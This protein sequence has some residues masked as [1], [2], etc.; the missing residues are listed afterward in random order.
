VKLGMSL[1]GRTALASGA[2]KWITGE[3]ARE[4]VQHWRARSSAVLTGIGTVLADD[5]RLDVRLPGAPRQPFRVILDSNLRTPAEARVLAGTGDTLIFTANPDAS[6]EQR[7]QERGA[8]IERAALTLPAPAQ[9]AGGR[10]AAARDGPP[11]R[12]DLPAVLARLAALQMNEVLVEAGPT[13]VGE[14]VGLG[15]ADEL[16]IYIAPKLLGPQAGPLLDLPLLE[17]LQQA[18]RFGIIGQHKVGDDLRLRLRPA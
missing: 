5:P 1:D 13:L 6:I 17:D 8:R 11:A 3:A 9:A 12:V 10:P 2:S 4:D 16:L 7:L 15:L 14:F 18:R